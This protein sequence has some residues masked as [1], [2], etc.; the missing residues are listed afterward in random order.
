[1]VVRGARRRASELEVLIEK[2]SQSPGRQGTQASGFLDNT[3][4]SITAVKGALSQFLKGL[5][6]HDSAEGLDK[7]EAT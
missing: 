1:V 3:C 6:T 4:M 7:E 5:G 2:L